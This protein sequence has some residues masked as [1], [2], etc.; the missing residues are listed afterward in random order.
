[1]CTP[2]SGSDS[3]ARR[4]NS[5]TSRDL[6]AP[7]SPTT[8]TRRGRRSS[9]TV[10]CTASSSASS[11]SRPTNEVRGARRVV[12]KA[13]SRGHGLRALV[14]DRVLR[15][16]GGQ[17][18]GQHAAPGAP[19]SSAARP[20]RAR[21]RPARR[22]ARSRRRWRRGAR[23]R[24]IRSAA[25]TARSASS[26]CARGTPN[27]P[28][29]TSSP[30]GSTLRLEPL[31]LLARAVGRRR[32]PARTTV[33]S[34]RSSRG[35]RRGRRRG[36]LGEQPL[37]QRR[38]RSAPGIAPEL[39]AQ[40]HAQV[41]VG[42]QRL[43]DVAARGQRLHQQQ[44]AGLAER[45]R[46]DD[47]ARRRARRRRCRSRRARA[48]RC[49][50]ARACAGAAPRARAGAARPTAWSCASRNGAAVTSSTSW[51]AR[52]TS[53][54]S[55]ALEG[56]LGALEV[57]V[58]RPR[59]RSTRR[60]AARARAR[61]GPASVPGPSAART[62]REQ[63]ASARR[64]GWRAPSRGHSSSISS[65]RATGRAAVPGQVGDDEPAPGGRAGRSRGRRA[66]PPAAR[67]GG[68]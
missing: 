31:E 34:L 55:D 10:R 11:W 50:S 47:R 39:V 9:S 49:R 66:R 12:R 33:T 51:P 16:A 48:P 62:L 5:S 35:G 60:P 19:A 59:R 68:C 22:R 45:R 17:L 61:G 57:G 3:R 44:V 7:A 21:R 6:P 63:R 4:R 40:P 46:L 27:T 14:V 43:G 28:T 53:A 32:T 38:A 20:R 26:S 37:V 67:T 52:H 64:R 41:L 25:S 36:S 18:V 15:Q 54:Q 29:T 56:R 42:A 2:A 65:S 23:G 58:R 30:A 13:R 1:M 24:P 8:T